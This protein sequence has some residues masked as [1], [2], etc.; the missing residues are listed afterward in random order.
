MSNIAEKISDSELEIMKTLW[1]AGDAL[2]ITDIRTDL[3]TRKGWEAT[4]IKT[5]VGRLVNKGAVLQEKRKVFY[6]SPLVT[7]EEYSRWATKDLVSKLY[8][9]SAKHLVAALVN[10][11]GLSKEDIDELRE[12]FKMED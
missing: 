6:Y 9:G 12:L 8:G 3:Q 5:L 10:S 1:E 4:T 11:D 2:T 7:E